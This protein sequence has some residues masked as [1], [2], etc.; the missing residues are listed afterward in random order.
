MNPDRTVCIYEAASNNDAN[1]LAMFLNDE[2]IEALA[3][4]DNS[5][6]GL[7]ALGALPGIHRPKVFV[8]RDNAQVALEMVERFE[9]K[10]PVSGKI[11]ESLFCY[12]CG[13]EC[14]PETEV[15]AD[16]GQILDQDDEPSDRDL[17]RQWANLED[18]SGAP[19]VRGFRKPVRILPLLA[20]IIILGIVAIVC[21]VS[22]S[23]LGGRAVSL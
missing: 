11:S 21:F 8:H 12:H 22:S 10:E 1:L 6:V 13:T 5:A 17:A 16:C 15:C 7:Y 23:D 14:K 4:E 18:K 20:V 2:G 19:A 9:K 3:V